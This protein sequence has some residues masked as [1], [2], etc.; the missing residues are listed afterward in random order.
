VVGL[1]NLLNWFEKKP[2]FG[3]GIVITRPEAQAGGMIDLLRQQGARVICFPTI[4]VVPPESWQALDKTLEHL[5]TYRWII[6]T[7][8]NGV[9]FFFKRP[10]RIG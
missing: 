6:F 8:A 7:S 3:R 1:R 4:K 9:H 2:L 5:E 10:E